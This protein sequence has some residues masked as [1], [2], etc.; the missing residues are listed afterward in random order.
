MNGQQWAQDNGDLTIGANHSTTGA[1][2][3]AP[4]P[5]EPSAA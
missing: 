5:L 1:K 2:G 3:T 4:K